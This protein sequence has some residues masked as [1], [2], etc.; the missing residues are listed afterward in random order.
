MHHD[1]E[2]GGHKKAAGPNEREGKKRKKFSSGLFWSKSEPAGSYFP[3]ERKIKEVE[4]D[5]SFVV[6]WGGKDL[7]G[8]E[9]G[10]D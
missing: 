9:T 3:Y 1:S 4:K 6:L 10:G 2:K 8:G 7:S 5:E